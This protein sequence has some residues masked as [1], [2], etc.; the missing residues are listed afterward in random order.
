MNP[1]IHAPAM[2]TAKYLK[3][4]DYGRNWMVC[5][6]VVRNVSED[7]G[8]AGSKR[9]VMSIAPGKP[10]TVEI[11]KP[12]IMAEETAKLTAIGANFEVKKRKIARRKSKIS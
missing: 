10:I 7:L 5:T 3:L 1:R 8:L 6:K 2:Y 9:L 11:A 12:E 4:Y